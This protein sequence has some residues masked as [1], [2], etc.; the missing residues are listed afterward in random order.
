VKELLE[1][2]G[3]LFKLYFDIHCPYF[4]IVI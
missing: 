1:H 2:I 3:V 4:H